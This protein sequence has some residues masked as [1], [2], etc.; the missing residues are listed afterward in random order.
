MKAEM[1]NAEC[2][3]LNGCWVLG[4]GCWDVFH[5]HLTPNT[6]NLFSIHHSSF[7]IPHLLRG[8]CL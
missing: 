1:M 3:M 6:Q 8:V 4:A 2:G 7:I 5:Q